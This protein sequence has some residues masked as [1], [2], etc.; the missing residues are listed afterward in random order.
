MMHKS[1]L[2]SLG[3]VAA[4]GLTSSCGINGGI[5]DLPGCGNTFYTLQLGRQ[6]IG[7][8]ERVPVSLF[9][10]NPCNHDLEFRFLAQ[11]GQVLSANPLVPGGE[12]ERSGDLPEHGLGLGVGEAVAPAG[13]AAAR[14]DGRGAQQ[15]HLT[16]VGALADQQ[17]GCRVSAGG[18]CGDA[19][20]PPLARERGARG[21]RA[22]EEEEIDDA[23]PTV[24]HQ[25]QPPPVAGPALQT[26][27][28]ASARS[29]MPSMPS[30]A[31]PVG[32]PCALPL[33]QMSSLSTRP[34]LP[35]SVLTP[36]S[37]REQSECLKALVTASCTM[38]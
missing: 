9:L 35:C 32:M 29:R 27:P 34:S 23:P 11:R 4:I 16:A 15:G 10:N 36:I 37:R 17:R 22:V 38:R 3:A 18:M 14:G 7:I 19:G 1:L 24:G 2:L 26:P 21:V 31:T 28:S 30:P 13:L 6:N 25:R 33:S 20:A 12:W 8:N 5:I